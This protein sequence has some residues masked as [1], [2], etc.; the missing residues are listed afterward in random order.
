[1]SARRSEPAVETDVLIVGGG[2]VG[3]LLAN[4]LG[5]ANIRTLVLERR[6]APPVQSMAIGVTPPSLEILRPLGL[7]TEFVRAGVPVRNAG[8]HENG[9]LLGRLSFD[10]I[11]T[12]YPFFLSVPQSDTVTVLRQKV[13]QWPSVLF[14]ED[15]EFLSLQQ[16]EARVSLTARDLLADRDFEFH[17]RHVIGCDGH[18][19]PVRQ[20]AGIPTRLRHYRQRWIMGDFDDTTGLGNEAHLY[21]SAKGS[22]ESFPLPDGRRRW[23]A[24]LNE[25]DERA[26]PVAEL[27]RRTQENAGH[28]LSN[29][30][31]ATLSTFGAKRQ[32]ARWFRKGRVLLCGDAAHVMSSIGGQGMNTG[33]AAAELLAKALTEALANPA[34]ADR[35]FG[36]WERL[37]RQ[38]F[39]VAADRAASGMWL[40]T[41][42]GRIASRLR[43]HVIRDILFSPLMRPRLAPHF[44]MLTIPNRNLAHTAPDLIGRPQSA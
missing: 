23:I 36:L 43:R 27:I 41:L 6:H 7:D 18:R 44:A 1:M 16:K 20:A 3:L 9:E 31:P 2:P 29:Q 37:R 34:S 15:H 25:K 10:G 39:N 35:V 13:R 26:D 14:L 21:F 17:A 40:G 4:L 38:A 5:H 11:P 8:V 22:V 32:L 24:Q 30:T 42:R 19:S 12:D 33:L 28:D